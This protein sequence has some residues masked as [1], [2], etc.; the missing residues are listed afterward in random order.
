MCHLLGWSNP[1]MIE[2]PLT[3][4]ADMSS[5]FVAQVNHPFGWTIDA[6]YYIHFSSKI[7]PTRHGSNSAW[8]RDGMT[9]STALP[10]GVHVAPN[11]SSTLRRSPPVWW[12]H[13]SGEMP[14]D[15]DGERRERILNFV[16]GVGWE[17]RRCE[18]EPRS[19]DGNHRVRKPLLYLFAIA[20]LSTSWAS[21]IAV[22][23]RGFDT[24]ILMCSRGGMVL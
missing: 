20:M 5:T 2:P 13:P 21:Q 6:V 10:R 7:P 18:G 17:R 24:R 19:I 14:E 16:P 15:P 23:S 9:T 3:Y 22:C 8:N 11:K 4:E 12:R 1:T